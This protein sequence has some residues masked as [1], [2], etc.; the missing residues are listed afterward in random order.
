MLSL[1]L[2]GFSQSSMF[3]NIYTSTFGNGEQSNAIVKDA[4]G[5]LYV[6]GDFSSICVIGGDTLRLS[7]SDNFFLAKCDPNSGFLWAVAPDCSYSVFGKTITIDNS[8]FIYISGS[9]RG[10][11]NFGNGIQLNSNLYTTF[12]AKYSSLGEIIWAKAFET[13]ESSTPCAITTNS[14][15]N[16]IITGNFTKYLIFEG[17]SLY[18]WKTAC[19]VLK[20]DSDGNAEW[21]IQTTGSGD[22]YPSSLGIDSSGDLVITGVFF[23]AITFGTYTLPGLNPGYSSNDIF[24]CKINDEGNFVWAVQS[25]GYGYDYSK[26]VVCGN[27]GSIYI[28]GMYEEEAQFGPYE[29]STG[30]GLYSY[31][32]YIA[33]MNSNGNFVWAKSIDIMVR[34]NNLMCIDPKNNLYITS[35]FHG[36]IEIGPSILHSQG[37]GDVYIL[38]MDKDG[39]I[40]YAKDAGSQ[41]E[42]IGAGIVFLPNGDLAVTGHISSEAIFDSIQVPNNSGSAFIAIL[43]Q[44]GPIQVNEI[45]YQSASSSN[46]GDWVEILNSG[47]EVVDLQ[48]WSLKDGNDNNIYTIS[49]TTL[50]SPDHYLVLCQDLDKFRTINPNILNCQGSFN[51][52]LAANGEKIRL[53]DN[54][55]LLISQVYYKTTFPW[56]TLLEGSGKTLELLDI[57]DELSDGN[58]WFAGCVGGSPGRSYFDCA[59]AGLDDLNSKTALTIYPNPVTDMLSILFS[60]L[61]KTDAELV[62]YDLQGRIVKKELFGQINPGKNTISCSVEDIPEGFYSMKF[63]TSGNFYYEKFIVQ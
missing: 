31:D 25:G 62:I 61:Y 44:S 59:S 19:Y 8:G 45:N 32:T 2:T 36:A 21:M 50:L 15:G 17:D 58:N 52:D 43:D 35:S 9:F 42:D 6:V 22:C 20:A 60:S 13:T 48:N 5:K 10:N 51:F 3:T 4:F 53:F 27:D 34:T 14:T 49:A 23:N 40:L 63:I 39:Q 16:I 54:N 18:S 38:K 26:S 46:T 28:A 41:Y 1:S 56:P 11:L 7:G 29:L 33:K 37:Y 24:I 30:L 47:S 12:I 55:D 57:E